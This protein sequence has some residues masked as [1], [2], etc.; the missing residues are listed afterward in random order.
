ML[1]EVRL[2]LF[3]T[4]VVHGA[5]SMTV[6]R[7]LEMATLGGAKNL[8]RSNELGSLEVGKRGDIA[9]FPAEDI[10][11]NGAEN[12]VHALFYC[13]P[14]NVQTLLVEGNV[15]V[16]DGQLVGVNLEELLAQHRKAA[17]R[18]QQSVR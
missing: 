18:L 6:D 10:W 5:G 13:H 1:N 8:G 3:L 7:A 14:R 9:I 17:R 4:R 16:R 12:P 15:R 11:S 2:A